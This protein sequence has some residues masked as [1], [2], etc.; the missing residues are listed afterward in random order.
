M[1][2]ACYQ[3]NCT[4]V[5]TAPDPGYSTARKRK[6]LVADISATVLDIVVIMNGKVEK[7]IV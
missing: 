2:S 5:G 3:H 7:L 6:A 4:T 1:T